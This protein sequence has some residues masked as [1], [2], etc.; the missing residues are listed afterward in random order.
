MDAADRMARWIM[1]V[2]WII[3]LFLLAGAVKA[4]WVV[5]TRW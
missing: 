3:G 5:L 1:G 4:A 2:A